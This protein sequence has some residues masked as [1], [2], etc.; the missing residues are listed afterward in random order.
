MKNTNI[1]HRFFRALVDIL[2]MG[3]KIKR[4]Y[5]DFYKF[6]SK[7]KTEIKKQN[8]IFFFK[9][10][11]FTS[12]EYLVENSKRDQKIT[13]SLTSYGGRIDYVY[14]IIESLGQQTV[15]AD[16]IVLWLSKD[17]FSTETIPITLKRMEERGLE[18]G[19]C[20][21]LR[22]YK[23]IVPSLEKYPND[24][25]IT[26]DDDIL[27]PEYMIEKLYRAY[28][29]EPG[30]IHC[31]RGHKILSNGKGLLQPYRKWDRDCFQFEKSLMVFPTS[32]GGA[33]YY[34]G[35]FSE[36]VVNKEL[37]MKLCPTADDVWL[38]ALTLNKGVYCKII[39]RT[40]LWR[41]DFTDITVPVDKGL[42]VINKY[43]NDEQINNVF[44]YFNI[45]N[46]FKNP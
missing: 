11:A 12:S 20:E 45:W 33:L 3:S 6:R 26:A 14:L 2:L 35:C 10:M 18:I 28:Q 17:E 24:L 25:I 9:R 29:K 41:D 34:P 46:V 36:E 4:L 13:V 44:D 16:R 1:F 15:K 8:A 21:D 30:V 19:Y 37:F 43:K 38:K 27:Y 40:R 32:G 5:H 22:S 39:N 31:H 23:K 7:Y 42:Y